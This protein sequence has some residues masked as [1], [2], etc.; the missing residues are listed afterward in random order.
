VYVFC[1]E[2]T[3]GN[4]IRHANDSATLRAIFSPDDFLKLFIDNSLTVD[5]GRFSET[6]WYFDVLKKEKV[7]KI[8][9][10][11]TRPERLMLSYGQKANVFSAAKFKTLS[12]IRNS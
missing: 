7:I 2:T 6:L 10:V 9:N 12:F 5:F 8:E 1:A 11:L 4:N 3:S